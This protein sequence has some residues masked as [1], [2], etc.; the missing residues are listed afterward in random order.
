MFVYSDDYDLDWP[1]HLFPTTKYRLLYERVLAEEVARKEEVLSPVPASDD[2][3]K[4][5]HGLRYMDTL[6]A[7]TA[8]PNM[9]IW[10]GFEA[11]ITSK[12]LQ[13]LYSCTGGTILAA[14]KAFAQ[15]QF[16]LNLGGGFHHAFPDRGEGFCFINDVAVAARALQRDTQVGRIVVVDCDLHQ[17][18]GTAKIFED[19]ASVVTFSIHQ[20]NLY[21]PKERS[22]IDVGLADDVGDEEYLVK[23]EDGLKRAFEGQS[24]DLMFFLAG[25]DP[26]VHDQL[27][28][29]QL[30]KDGLMRRDEVVLATAASHNLPVAVTLAGGYAHRTQDVVDIHL[31]TARLVATYN[32]R[33]AIGS[34]SSESGDRRRPHA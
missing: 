21:P 29:L 32:R 10:A 28:S 30:T 6:R 25:A 20:E 8:D 7:M 27:G 1:R 34:P 26:Y 16:W 31:N 19:E 23:L 3:M 5:V 24:F 13:A 18:N 9:A 22:N 33:G 15:K 4:L 14:K 2:D 12:T 17:G 11:P